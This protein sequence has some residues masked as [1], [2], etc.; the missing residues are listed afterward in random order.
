M[1]A[2]IN[3]PYARREGLREVRCGRCPQKRLLAHMSKDGRTLHPNENASV[4]S[5]RVG[6]RC[7]CGGLTEWRPSRG[8][9]TRRT[10][11][12]RADSLTRPGRS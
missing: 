1:P 2:L 12:K 3:E 9:E 5:G 6:L 8:I 7:K 4:T 10:A 11:A